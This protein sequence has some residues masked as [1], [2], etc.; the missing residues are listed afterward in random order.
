MSTKKTIWI[1]Y[2]LGLKG[3]YSQLYSWLDERDAKECGNSIAYIATDE[4]NGNIPK[5]LKNSLEDTIKFSPT[6]RVYIIYKDGN[7][8]KGKFLFGN[9]KP[10]V[11]HGYSIGS[12]DDGE[13]E[14]SI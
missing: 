8:M 13:T 5:E 7:K 1:S 14:D 4:F 12:E 3:N 2:D 9:R 10:P 11:W 6:D